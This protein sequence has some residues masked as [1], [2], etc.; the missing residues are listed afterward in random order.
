MALER[1]FQYYRTHQQELVAKYSG[2]VLAIKNDVV[3]GV[4]ET[5][6]AAVQ[7]ISKQH[8][9]GTFLVQR[10]EPGADSYTQTFHSRV[11]AFA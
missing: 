3:L 9:L 6:I 5:E 8:P 11:S 4:F 1:E 7:E 2:K 10:C